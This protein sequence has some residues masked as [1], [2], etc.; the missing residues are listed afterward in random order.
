ML[1]NLF[2]EILN[3]TLTGSFV[4][5]GVIVARF[6][7]L[8]FPKK[9][10]YLLWAIVLVRLLVPISWESDLSL[11]PTTSQPIFTP[12]M[13]YETVP[14]VDTG[15][16][17]LD[18]VINPILPPVTQPEAS[19]NPI[20]IWIFVGRV[21][22]MTGMT[23]MAVYGLVQYILLKRKLATAIPLEN[24]IYL[25]DNIPSPFVLGLI[26]PKIYLPSHLEEQERGYI[27]AHEQCHLKRFDHVTRV[28]AFVALTVHW[29]NP[30]VW[31]AFVLSE[32][33]M[34]R[35]CDEAVMGTMEGDIRRDYANSLL[36]FASRGRLISATPLAFGEGD[37][38][39]R[40]KNV[41]GYK[42]PVV[43]VTVVAIVL[44]V[45]V[46]VGLMSNAKE[47]YFPLQSN[48]LSDLNPDEILQNIENITGYSSGSLHLTPDNFGLTVDADFNMV[49][50][51]AIRFLYSEDG[52][53]M[54][55]QLRIFLT[56]DNRFFV[57]EPDPWVAP[58]EQVF[59]LY[60]YLS[61]LK[62]LPTDAIGEMAG[63]APDRYAIELSRN[64]TKYNADRMIYYTQNGVEQTD[65][66][67]IRLDIQ[68]LYSD[69]GSGYTGVGHD[70]IHAF[71]SDDTTISTDYDSDSL[72]QAISDGA[73]VYNSD[74]VISGREYLDAFEEASAN[75]EDGS[76]RCVHQFT[77]DGAE[78][79]TSA[80]TDIVYE[81]ELFTV[82]QYPT[83]PE[84]T[85][86]VN[87]YQY[88]VT[89]TV[90]PMSSTAKYETCRA[91]YL[92]N[93]PN[94]TYQDIMNGFLSSQLGA[95]EDAYVIYVEFIYP[96]E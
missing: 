31:M 54:A 58:T 8:K 71:Y 30:L 65:G 45:C 32:R 15:V 43:W 17:V 83:T 34:E 62:Y 48:A 42:K 3:L 69:G 19:V 56:E 84:E 66:W 25:A 12:E 22:W 79:P 18:E 81:N 46:G 39:G 13:V 94:V 75:R 11:I 77:P 5:L 16:E 82:T 33:D 55:S 10:S 14:Q 89:E 96:E 9:Y 47:R 72:D 52:E 80:V 87:T 74:G 64:D 91:Y 68:P 63:D 41:M 6:L 2:V 61:A 90:P 20:Q 92:V 53:T 50:D 36:R 88:L 76:L 21:L 4:I 40:V 73:F 26:R 24:R 93:D 60:H 7:M 38:K 37:T 85:Q 95:A 29:F 27:I 1:D 57:T 70:I 78:E 44:A 28:L 67:L 86:L 23:A 51:E 35:S 49:Q 59:H